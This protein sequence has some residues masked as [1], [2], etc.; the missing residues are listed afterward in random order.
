M[1]LPGLDLTQPRPGT[2]LVSTLRAKH[3]RR[4]KGFVRGAEFAGAQ[5][6]H[7]PSV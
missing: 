3:K 2:L 6:E 5:L 7:P 1:C 4:A